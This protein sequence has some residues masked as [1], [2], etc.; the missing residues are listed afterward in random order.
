[1]LTANTF[2]NALVTPEERTAS[3]GILQG[4]FMFGSTLGFSIGGVVGDYLGDAAPFEVTLT[5]LVISTILS[6]VFLPYIAP[7]PSDEKDGAGIGSVL[8]PLLVLGPR[9]IKKEDGGD[10]KRYWG[11]TLL[12]FGTGEQGLLSS[13]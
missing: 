11:V 10:G 3:F 8:K 6:S 5:L 9:R 2:V 7:E 1:M 4:T 13:S 12:A